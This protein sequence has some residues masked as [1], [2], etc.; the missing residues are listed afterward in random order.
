GYFVGAVF[1]TT[2]QAMPFGAIS[3]VILSAMGGIWVPADIFS[4]LM[5]KVAMLSPLYWA[6]DAVNQ[7]TFRNGSI[8]AVLPHIAVLAVFSSILFIISTHRNKRRVRSVQ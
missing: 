4:P 7:V 2:N 5:Q 1:K 3:I 8:D 6:L